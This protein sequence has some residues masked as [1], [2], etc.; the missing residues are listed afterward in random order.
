MPSSVM[1]FVPL[2]PRLQYLVPRVAAVPLYLGNQW[3]GEPLAEHV[4]CLVLL[5]SKFSARM[6]LE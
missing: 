4:Q 1:G 6:G 5:N 3:D 2:L